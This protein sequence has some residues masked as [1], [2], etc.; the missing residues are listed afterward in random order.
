MIE[1]T[2][3]LADIEYRRTHL[4]ETL[5]EACA[6]NGIQGNQYRK[7]KADE[8]IYAKTKNRLAK[9]LCK[10]RTPLFV[11][12]NIETPLLEWF[13]RMQSQGLAIDYNMIVA[14]ACELSD[15][16]KERSTFTAQYSAARLFVQRHG[17]VR[18]RKTREAQCAPLR[19]SG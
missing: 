4:N 13:H 15:E 3:I 12:Y 7:W 16:F 9:S 5:T 18:Q 19:V 10:G 1:R 2:K 17:L 14:K 11:R 8:P 6:A